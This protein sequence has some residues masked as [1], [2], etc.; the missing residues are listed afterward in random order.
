MVQGSFCTTECEFTRLLGILQQRSHSAVRHRVQNGVRNPQEDCEQEDA[1]E[2][3]HAL[4]LHPSLPTHRVPFVHKLKYV[5]S[6]LQAVRQFL[7]I[8]NRM[9]HTE[10]R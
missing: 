4:N 7:M 8:C 10:T 5:R 3:L 9:S 1:V 6:A 2:C